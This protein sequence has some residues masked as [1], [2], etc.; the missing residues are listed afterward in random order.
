MKRLRGRLKRWEV[1]EVADFW[2]RVSVALTTINMLLYLGYAI[3][4]EGDLLDWL[5]Y[6]DLILPFV[7][8]SYALSV[9]MKP[10]R[11][12]T[13]YEHVFFNAHFCQFVV[14]SELLSLSG[15]IRS[16]NVVLSVVAISPAAMYTAGFKLLLRFRK[17]IGT[18]QK[19]RSL[20]F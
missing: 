15:S 17:S 18:F 8:L 19:Q 10:L 11:N 12:N 9:L 6:A 16:Q 1:T 13:N 2:V 4:S 3:D 20:V 14:I 5:V 7:G